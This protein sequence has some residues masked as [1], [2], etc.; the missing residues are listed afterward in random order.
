LLCTNG[1]TETVDAETIRSILRGTGSADE[2]CS[3][4]IETAMSGGGDNVIV[5][6]ARYHFPENA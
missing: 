5:V 3:A 1:F 2:A 6:L 4:L